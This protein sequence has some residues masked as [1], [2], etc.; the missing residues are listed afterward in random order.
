M[1]HST[2]PTKA[3]IENTQLGGACDMA[4]GDWAAPLGEDSKSRQSWD[5]V[6][7]VSST[8]L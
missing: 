8:S 3:N 7:E 2:D 5:K 4:G 1:Q 6:A